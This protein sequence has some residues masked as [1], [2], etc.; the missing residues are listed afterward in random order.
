VRGYKDAAAQLRSL[1]TRYGDRDRLG[2]PLA[3]L[4]GMGYPRSF[5][6]ANT[7]LVGMVLLALGIWMAATGA[8]RVLLLTRASD[9]RGAVDEDIDDNVI[10][11]RSA[12]K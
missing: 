1:L 3:L 9:G 8:V 10:V 7:P 4:L 12:R 2:L 5:F 11:W 6:D